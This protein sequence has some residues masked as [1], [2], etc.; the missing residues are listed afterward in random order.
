MITGDSGT[1]SHDP[2]V[3]SHK[4]GDRNKLRDRS[5]ERIRVDGWADFG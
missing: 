2:E 5:I 4:L 3:R 1:G